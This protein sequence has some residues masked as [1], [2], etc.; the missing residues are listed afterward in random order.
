M[1]GAQYDVFRYGKEAVPTATLDGAGTT[2]NLPSY[3]K[4]DGI[5]TY[6]VDKD[7]VQL[8]GVDQLISLG[9]SSVTI[10]STTPTIIKS[11]TKPFAV[12][13]GEA[14]SNVVSGYNVKVGDV[15]YNST[16]KIQAKVV[17]LI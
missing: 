15:I 4:G 3:L 14:T 13:S 8:Y 16:T 11:A 17:K 7:S 6:T 1:V 5:T 2:F 10:D 9:E 12:S